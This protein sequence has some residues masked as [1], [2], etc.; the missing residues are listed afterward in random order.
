[1]QTTRRGVTGALAVMGMTRRTAAQAKTS[2]K[3]T[4][5]PG[6]IYMPTFIMEARRSIET[7]AASL[8]VPDVSVEFITFNGGGGATDALLAGSVEMV[9]TGASNMLLLWDRTRGR[10]KGV[11]ATC[12]EPLFLISR[13]PRIQ[14][15][16]DFGASDKIAVPTVRISTQA[17]LL[18]I[19]CAQAFGPDQSGRLDAN[20]VQLG[21]PD[22]MAALLNPRGELGSHFAVPPFHD[23]ELRRVPG[24]HVVTDSLRILGEK[25]T[26]GVLFTT[27]A[28]ADANPAVVRAARDAV[29]EAVGMIRDDT[30]EAVRLYLKAS[31]DPIGEDA[32]ME[33][34]KQPGMLDFHAEPQG[35]MRFARHLFQTGV[36]KTE[37]KAWTDYFLPV[38]AGLDGS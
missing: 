35:T 4:R 1:M 18:Q 10:V 23:Q 5:Q 36:L 3:I 7:H 32:L 20:T 8:G 2:I 6:L 13:E 12:A 37:P 33:L 28:F 22:A 34:F 25:L 26:S 38:A 15:I 29:A 24:A 16:E 17:I 14:R 9:N 11:V 30:R 31:A 19:A 27:Q 21:M